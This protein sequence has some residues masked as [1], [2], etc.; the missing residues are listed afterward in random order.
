ML[1]KNEPP[2]N[3]E[4]TARL[5]ASLRQKR[6]WSV[7][8]LIVTLLIVATL[9]AGLVWLFYPQPD[10]P[11]IVLVAIDRFAV[12]GEPTIL[13]AR[14]ELA[15]P[16]ERTADLSG[17]ELSFETGV[18]AD[19]T[20][21]GCA[22]TAADGE[23]SLTWQP[24]K[25]E[26]LRLF[27]VR[28]AGD[29]HRR[30]AASQARLVLLDPK[31]PCLLVDVAALAPVDVD[32][33]RARNV[34]E[35]RPASGAGAAL[36]AAHKKG[37]SIV[38]AA[39]AADSVPLYT[40]MRGWVEMQ[41]TAR[42][43]LPG[44]PA[45]ARRAADFAGPAPTGLRGIVNEELKGLKGPVIAVVAGADMV[46]ALRGTGMKTLLIGADPV[47]A[48]ALRLDSWADLEARLEQLK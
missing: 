25:D 48:P 13:R 43:P 10:P 35:I 17:Y 1:R 9:I 37:Y 38:Y 32:T 29:K 15:Q 21:L 2:S 14:I 12:P 7:R 28:Y 42:E 22:K 26:P 4:L 5:R 8:G 45:L 44:G 18:L 36:L 6:S 30:P 20:A 23:A 40:K 27:T 46:V 11:P 19:T 31:A 41:A 16:A 47:E 39:S 24:A 34:F 3:D 33:W